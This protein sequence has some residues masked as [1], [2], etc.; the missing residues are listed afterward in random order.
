[1]LKKRFKKT[2]PWIIH[3]FN[4]NQE[5]ANQLIK[6]N[7]AISFGA[8]LRTSQKL[9][10]ILKSI[11]DD[12]FFLETDGSDISPKSLYQMAADLKKSQLLINKTPVLKKMFSLC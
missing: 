10:Q 2:T 11:P 5:I 12:M 9:Q 3:G 7:I 6:E 4:A 8:N 1:M